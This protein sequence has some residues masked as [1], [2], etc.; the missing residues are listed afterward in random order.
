MQN[1]TLDL[2]KFPKPKEVIIQR[3][4]SESVDNVNRTLKFYLRVI[5]NEMINI[6]MVVIVSALILFIVLVLMLLI[7][8]FQPSSLKFW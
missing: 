1:D 7:Y 3:Q 4:G 5:A 2:R 8:D 6:Q